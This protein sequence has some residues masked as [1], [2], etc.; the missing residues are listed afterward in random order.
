MF[1][2]QDVYETIQQQYSQL[3]TSTLIF[4]SHLLSLSAPPLT[5]HLPTTL[6]PPNPQAPRHVLCEQSEPFQKLQL[7]LPR[8][9]LPDEHLAFIAQAE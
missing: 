5:S 6:C 4:L 2:V 8:L 9:T 7:P 3:Q 1:I